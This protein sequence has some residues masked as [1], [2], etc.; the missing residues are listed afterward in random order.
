MNMR[1]RFTIVQSLLIVGS[2][3][4]ISGCG[5]QTGSAAFSNQPRTSPWSLQWISSTTSPALLPAAFAASAYAVDPTGN[6]N[7]PNTVTWL[8]TTSTFGLAI[9]YLDPAKQN[10]ALAYFAHSEEWQLEAVVSVTEPTAAT[11]YTGSDLLSLPQGS[12][13]SASG[14]RA[15]EPSS[16]IQLWLSS[17]HTFAFA[18]VP[19]SLGTSPSGTQSVVIRDHNGWLIHDVSL[20]TAIVSIG[21]RLLVFSGTVP[22]NQ[23]LALTGQCIDKLSQLTRSTPPQ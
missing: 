21:D 11:G 9:V 20:S 4:A 7:V 13:S 3:V 10:V 23:I 22:D 1:K 8:L 14:V 16:T 5:Q 18:F 12:Y 15:T 2:I 19:E 6:R 17:Q